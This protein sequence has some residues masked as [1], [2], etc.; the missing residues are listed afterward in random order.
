[1]G[2]GNL[3]GEILA[4]LNSEMLFAKKKLVVLNEAE[5]FKTSDFKT[6]LD[7]KKNSETILV[8]IGHWKSDFKKIF[9]KYGVQTVDCWNPFPQELERI[10]REEAGKNG[11]SIGSDAVRLIVS[12]SKN[13]TKTILENLGKT[14]SFSEGKKEITEET[15][16]EICVE[17]PYENTFEFAEVLFL[18][19]A[20][21]ADR[22]LAKLD[23][24]QHF[25]CLAYLIKNVERALVLWDLKRKG[26][27]EEGFKKM[28]IWKK[29]QDF[30][31]KLV[32]LPVW[33]LE[34]IY[35]IL[36]EAEENLKSGV[37]H[38]FENAVAKISGI[39]GQFR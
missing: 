35:P 23:K 11:F 7:F 16:R 37:P 4:E 13:D 33:K 14:I 3:P 30:F 34:K 9:P 29:Q 18:K 10:V 17:D 31:R 1:M 19:N 5:K 20:A 6:I 8:L 32:S 27:M 2:A 12:L 38:A 22:A 15:I 25:P 28:K 21:E 36:L 26:D 24:K 39:L